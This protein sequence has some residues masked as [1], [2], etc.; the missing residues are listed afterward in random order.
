MVNDHTVDYHPSPSGL[1]PQGHILLY[2]YGHPRA[3]SFSRIFVKFFLRPVY[4]NMTG[5]NFQ[6]YGVQIT[7]ACTC[8]SKNIQS[9]I[10]L[11]LPSKT[12]P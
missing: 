1:K 7:G 9:S 12:L 11:M 4:P 5:E 3:L 6:I 10:L 2:F 8:D